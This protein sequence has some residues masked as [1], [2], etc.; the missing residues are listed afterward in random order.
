MEI[1]L[2][3]SSRCCGQFGV[4][5]KRYSASQNYLRQSKSLMVNCPPR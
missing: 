3:I 2:E 5:V 4:S 1:V